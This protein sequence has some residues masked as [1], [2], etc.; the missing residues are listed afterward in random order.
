MHLQQLEGVSFVTRRYTKRVPF[1]LKMVCKGIRGWGGGSG[2]VGG[3]SSYN[4]LPSAPLAHLGYHYV[5]QREAVCSFAACY[6]HILCFLLSLVFNWNAAVYLASK[7]DV[8]SCDQFS[9]DTS[10]VSVRPIKTFL[11]DKPWIN[12]GGSTFPVRWWNLSNFVQNLQTSTAFVI[13][14]AI[15]GWLNILSKCL[16]M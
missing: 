3:P 16:I 13:S 1:L 12:Q 9:R 10:H 7:P 11:H 6:C 8:R 2:K 4:T 15:M 5:P 14:L